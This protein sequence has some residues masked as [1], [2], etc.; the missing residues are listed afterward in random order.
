MD[1]KAGHH[2]IKTSVFS[3]RMGLWQMI[4]WGGYSIAQAYLSMFYSFGA[5]FQCAIG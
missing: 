4:K 2:E 5:Q 3:A 1:V